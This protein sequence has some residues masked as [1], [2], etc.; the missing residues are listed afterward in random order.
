[1]KHY[2]IPEAGKFYKANL[3]THTTVSDGKLTPEEAKE[4]FVSLGYSVVA[5]TDHEVMVPHPELCDDNFIAIT[6]VEMAIN[7]KLW[8]P[9]TKTYHLNVYAPEVSRRVT[10]TFCYKKVKEI[11]RGNVSEEMI[12]G[13]VENRYYTKE[14]IQSFIDT[15]TAE[16]CLVC[17]N[18][19]EWSLQSK[20]DYS[21]LKGL[22]GVEWSNTGCV[23][24]GYV[25]NI[26][27]VVD[28]LREGERMC[29]P[30]AA[31]DCHGLIDYGGGWVQIKAP[32]LTYDD[33]FAAL[34]RGDFYSSTGPEIH[35]LYVEDGAVVVKTS[36]AA[37]V[38]FITDGRHTLTERY[39]KD[40]D[41]YV[42]ES[43][44]KLEKFLENSALADEGYSTWFRIEVTDKYG[45]KAM[46]KAYFADDI[47]NMIGEA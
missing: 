19:P 37:H 16:G 12:A 1:M 44:F 29:Y 8:A 28:L 45:K 6:G 35:E 20:E 42:T 4:K 5:F 34:R 24:N 26:K 13:G 11:W 21:G 2:L 9:Y 10:G 23:R 25:D 38:A 15:A 39:K 43:R 33:V 31:D 46:T 30:I 32:A 17:Y 14:Y 41:T 18:H 40:T 3:H 22:F 47:K 36:E 7:E 27:P